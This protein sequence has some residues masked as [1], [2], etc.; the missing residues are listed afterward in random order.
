EPTSALPDPEWLFEIV[1]SL[2]EEKEMTIFY[3]SHRLNE[4]RRICDSATILR[5][6]KSIESVSLEHATD[7][8]VFKMMI[9][10][11]ANERFKEHIPINNFN[12][13]PKNITVSNLEGNIVNN[14]SFSVHEGEILGIAGL[15]GQ[16]QDELF[17]ILS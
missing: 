4:I 6:G 11:T 5:N 13:S 7:D 15:E 2:K 14:V 3:I 10:D 8:D 16:G 12:N 9:G 17:K 1:D